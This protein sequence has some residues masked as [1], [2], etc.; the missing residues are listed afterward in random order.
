MRTPYYPDESKRYYKKYY[1]QQVGGNMDVFQGSTVQKGRGIGKFLKAA[2]KA[3]A[4]LL[5]TGAKTVGKELMSTGVGLAKDAI[6]GKNMK[7]AAEERFKAA[8]SSA[9][10]SFLSGN[11]SQSRPR[12]K[13]R[14]RPPPHPQKNKKQRRGKK[15]RSVFENVNV[16][17][18]R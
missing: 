17:T 18:S 10:E 11:S 16:S 15:S 8:G 14:K 9:L 12:P 6:A 3:T 2:L 7:Q 4:P 13:K 5:K 1:E